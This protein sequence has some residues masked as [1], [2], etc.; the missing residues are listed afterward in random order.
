MA[1]EQNQCDAL[2]PSRL[3]CEALCHLGRVKEAYHFCLSISER[4]E[5]V[6]TNTQFLGT[7]AALIESHNVRDLKTS[8][9][10]FAALGMVS[11]LKKRIESLNAHQEEETGDVEN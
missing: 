7:I 8:V 9:Q 4:E 3:L 5:N 1:L 11:V 2:L 10:D 6:Y